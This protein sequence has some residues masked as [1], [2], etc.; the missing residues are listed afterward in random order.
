[1]NYDKPPL[2]FEQQANLLIERGMTGDVEVIAQRLASVN[3][4][5]LSGYWYPFRNPDDSFKAG[6]SFE[7]VWNRYAFDRRFR[8]LV[9]DAIERVE[10][11]VRCQ[12][13][14]HLA[15]DFGAFGYATNPLALP[16]LRPEE[17]AQFLDRVRDEVN[18]SRETFVA[19]FKTKYGDVHSDLPIWMATEL[20]SFGSII[21]LF[22][23]SPKHTKN[24]IA[25][26]F[27]M[28]PEVL[29]SW[30]LSI[31]AVRNICAHHG[32]LWNRVLGVKPM[33]PRK[34]DYPVWHEPVKVENDRVFGML[35]ISNY[36]LARIAPQSRWSE[37]LRALFVEFPDIPQGDMGFPEDWSKSP[38]WLGRKPEGG[39]SASPEQEKAQS[40]NLDEIVQV[41]PAQFNLTD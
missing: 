40:K 23:G 28:P 38:L 2:N 3:Y 34:S 1:M 29:S 7:T 20:M 22:R 31:N 37:R 24:A 27:G 25:S 14:Y 36:C 12:L 17:R 8:L 15:H 6:T 21:T 9:M 26:T 33:I 39:Q 19:H 16:K 18:R 5:R 13:S 4:Y 41:S 32:R 10:I 11:A 30:L 35:T